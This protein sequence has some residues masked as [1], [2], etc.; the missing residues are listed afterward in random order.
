MFANYL[1]SMEEKLLI[2]KTTKMNNPKVKVFIE[3]LKDF[4]RWALSFFIG[5]ILDNGYAFFTKS[6]LDPAVIILI[7]TLFKYADYYWHKLNKETTMS[8]EGESQGILPF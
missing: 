7:G 3:V 6:K 8:R 1:L 4:F 5:W 2:K